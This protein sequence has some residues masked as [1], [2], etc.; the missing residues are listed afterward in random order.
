MATSQGL[1]W[2]PPGPNCTQHQSASQA[3]G[4]FNLDESKEE[5]YKPT[6][7]PKV[8][9]TCSRKGSTKFLVI[10]ITYWVNPYL[11]ISL[12]QPMNQDYL[13]NRFGC[14]HQLCEPGERPGCEEPPKAQPPCR[15]QQ[16]DVP[17]LSLSLSAFLMP[18]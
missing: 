6:E 5:N 13:V 12:D 11:L 4:T 18:L 10:Q 16:R 9:N 7:P 8:P 1:P 2:A 15:V 3:T 17:S 14:T